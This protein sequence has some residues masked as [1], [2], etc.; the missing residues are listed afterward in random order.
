MMMKINK[1]LCVAVVLVCMMVFAGCGKPKEKISVD[2]F[3]SHMEQAGLTMMEQS[4][5][6]ADDSGIIEVQVALAEDNLYQ[7]E[8]YQLDGVE[9]AH[10]F[11]NAA[12]DGIEESYGEANGNVKTNV[13][14][15]NY[16]KYT[17]SIE[18][19]YYIV[20]RID[21]TLVYVIAS[22]DSK[23]IVKA[24]VEEIGY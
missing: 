15:S 19:R 9:N 10:Y 1:K 16:D 21:D 7:V 22:G 18:G 17:M 6:I 5:D 23:D 11:Y 20:S 8:F 3:V 12:K 24:L 14:A 4:D 2:A 13:S